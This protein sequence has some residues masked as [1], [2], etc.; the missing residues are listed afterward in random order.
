MNK[1][2]ARAQLEFFRNL[3]S[4]RPVSKRLQKVPIDYW[5]IFTLFGLKAT[6]PYPCRMFGKQLVLKIIDELLEKDQIEMA[7]EVKLV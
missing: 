2:R 1:A 3:H 4:D 5:D 7:M 6:D